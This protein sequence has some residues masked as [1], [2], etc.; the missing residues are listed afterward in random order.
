MFWVYILRSEDGSYYTGHSDNL[1][2]RIGQCQAGEC[3]GYTVTDRPLRLAWWQVCA[4]Q[5]EA[6]LAER[7]IKGWSHGKK[8]A[9]M[10]GAWFEM[11]T[12]VFRL[13]QS[14]STHDSKRPC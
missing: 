13:V 10:R 1:E 3:A 8:E 14:Q 2:T 6:L 12:E 5:E 7:Q 9:M 11:D 4:T